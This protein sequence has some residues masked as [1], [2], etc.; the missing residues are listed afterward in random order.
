MKQK[1]FFL[2][3]LI[4]FVLA[5]CSSSNNVAPTEIVT[6]IT[7]TTV[8]PLP[9]TSSAVVNPGTFTTSPVPTATKPIQGKNHVSGTI[10]LVENGQKRPYAGAILYLAKTII[11]TNGNESFVAL[12]RINSPRVQANEQGYF[13]FTDLPEGNYGLILD[14]VR[15]SY[16]LHYPET[17]EPILVFVGTDSSIDIGELVYD[18]LPVTVE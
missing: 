8:A 11:D 18:D 12:D 3:F 13:V 17:N 9:I 15:D 10:F 1:I 16:F 6:L 7:P 5:A 14:T 4:L 2:G